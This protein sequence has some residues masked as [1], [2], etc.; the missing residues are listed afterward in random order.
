MSTGKENTL[1]PHV[2]I[3]AM[4]GTIAGVAPRA[5]QMSDYKAGSLTVQTLIDAVPKLNDIA[6][7]TGEQVSAVGSQNLNDSDL[8]KLAKCAND[9]LAAPDV[10]AVVVTHGTATLEESAY[11]LNLTVKNKKPVVFVGAQRPATAISADGPLNLLN[12]VRLAVDSQSAGKGVLIAMNDMFGGAREVTK[13][14]T[15]NVST[16]K[17]FELGVFGYMA[18]GQ[19]W[20]VNQSLKKHTYQS[21]FDIH[22][23]ERLPRVDIVYSHVNADRVPYDSA[24]NAGAK[25]IV[26]AGTGNGAFHYQEWSGIVDAIKNGVIV[27]RSS[28]IPCGPVTFNH[29]E[30]AD[31]GLIH[32]GTLNPQKARVLLQLALAHAKDRAAIQ[33]IFN[34]Y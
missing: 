15:T 34:E 13:T 17:S 2:H 26:I 5:D 7:V 31:A 20:F 25:G 23:I 21:E 16:F 19:N 14:N 24:V 28:R 10:T 11:F 12:A 27:V 29:K 1:R 6:D 32:S 33:R 22:A 8:I 9:A 3:L 18:V 4:G 30:W